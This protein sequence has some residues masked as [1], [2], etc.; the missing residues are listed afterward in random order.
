[1][2]PVPGTLAE[3]AAGFLSTQWGIVL[4]SLESQADDGPAPAREALAQLCESYW[5]PLYSF[6]RRRGYSSADAQDLVQSFFVY[7]LARKVHARADPAKGKF[8]TFLLAA[9]KH[10]LADAWDREQALKRG[11]GQRLVPLDERLLEIEATAL[12]A[13]T[14]GDHPA[15]MPGEDWLFEQRW[16][17][18]VVGRGMEHLRVSFVAEN[19]AWLLDELSPFISGAGPAPDQEQTAARLGIP[20]ATLRSHLRRLRGRY[21]EALRAE[22]AATISSSRPE[23][24]DEELRHLGRVLIA[25]GEPLG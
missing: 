3:G 12:A 8:R 17:I 21:R 10:F 18:A 6:V 2:K 9:L 24:I 5:P 13:S 11:S 1:M 22:I 4:R 15:G 25:R 20:P 14:G 19:K 16:A 7:L 23:D